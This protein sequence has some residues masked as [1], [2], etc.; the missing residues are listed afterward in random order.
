[1]HHEVLREKEQKLIELGKEIEIGGMRCRHLRN[2][3]AS[4]CMA[5]YRR[6]KIKSSI[7]L[8]KLTSLE[9]SLHKRC[10]QTRSLK[11]GETC[12][13]KMHVKSRDFFSNSA[14]AE[15]TELMELG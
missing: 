3:L 13:T 2:K 7:T 5:S 12:I 14:G 10:G 9:S 6:F 1:M 8:V 11:P 15:S 4:K